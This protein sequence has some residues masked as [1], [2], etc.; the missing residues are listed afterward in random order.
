MSSIVRALYHKWCDRTRDIEVRICRITGSRTSLT[1]TVTG[2]VSMGSSK[3]LDVAS[4]PFN[5]ALCDFRLGNLCTHEDN[6]LKDTVIM[7]P[8][9]KDAC[10][11]RAKKKSGR[12]FS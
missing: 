6:K 8:C 1:K 12:H 4:W 9:R 5:K 11:A 2:L 3:L 7:V 10:P